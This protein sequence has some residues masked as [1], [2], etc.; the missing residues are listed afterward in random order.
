MVL[1]NAYLHRFLIDNLLKTTL[2][3]IMIFD[4][5]DVEFTQNRNKPMILCLEYPSNFKGK[6]F[7]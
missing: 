7:Q 6:T 5:T 3:K 1:N 4:A 2:W